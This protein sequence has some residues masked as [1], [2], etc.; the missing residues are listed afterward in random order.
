MR[1]ILL[2]GLLVLAS[3]RVQA[4]F[5]EEKALDVSIGL[6]ISAPN[7]EYDILG[8]GFYAQAE[9]VLIHSAWFDL[10]PY[11]G[12]VFT[13]TAGEYKEKEA[14]GYKS[15]ANA[16]M[17]GG[18]TRLTAPIPWVAPYVE[19]GVG[20]SIGSFETVTPYTDIQDSGLFLHIPFS[21][22]LEL[23]RGHIINIEFTYYFHESVQQF[24]GAAALGVTIPLR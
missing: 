9:L 3:H 5:I 10:R 12:V 23:G 13:K 22:G 15:T 8:D 7:D 20:G 4:Q 2:A 17:F 24:S 1:R 16:F 14:L 6:G 19:I 18:K 11:A 21:F